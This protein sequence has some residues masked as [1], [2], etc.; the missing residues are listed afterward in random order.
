MER[1][2]VTATM[3]CQKAL[4]VVTESFRGSLNALNETPVTQKLLGPRS[5]SRFCVL[6][7]HHGLWHKFIQES[8][9]PNEAVHLQASS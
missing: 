8:V 4:R 7:R 2:K 3:K 1:H 6:N 5:V 9:S